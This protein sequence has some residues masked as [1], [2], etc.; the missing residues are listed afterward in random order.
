MEPYRVGLAIRK[1]NN[2]IRRY[3][4]FSSHKREVEA[5]TGNNEWIIG[6]LNR[7]QDRDIF[8]RDIEQ[9]FTITRSTASRVLSLMEKK[10]L[11]ERQS[12]AHDARLKKITLTE[13]AKDISA[14]MR[15]DADEMERQ[16]IKG[17]SEE[18]IKTLCTYIERMKAN[19]LNLPDNN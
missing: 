5:V 11:I 12:V 16:L 6:Y 19:L 7:N 1:L 14:I 9:Q 15:H 18:E 3:F 2:Q 10:G 17:F 13:K 4:E 8:Q